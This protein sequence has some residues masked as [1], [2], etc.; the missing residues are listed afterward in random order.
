MSLSSHRQRIVWFAV[1][2]ALTVIFAIGGIELSQR[3][4]DFGY[5][6]LIFGLPLAIIGMGIVGF[7][8]SRQ[9]R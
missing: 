2:V 1:L 6:M 8:L 4:N 5:L 3:G 7:S 9:E